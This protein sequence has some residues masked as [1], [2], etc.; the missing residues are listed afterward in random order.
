LCVAKVKRGPC[1]WHTC[2]RQWPTVS[3]IIADTADARPVH[4]AVVSPPGFAWFLRRRKS[5][6]IPARTAR[7]AS[8]HSSQRYVPRPYATFLLFWTRTVVHRGSPAEYR[9][10][11]INSVPAHRTAPPHH[12]HDLRDWYHE[13]DAW[14]L[15]MTVG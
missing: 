14:K 10:R 5:R 12:S 4:R 2:R 8:S 15:Q 7:P 13:R 11:L 3:R 1:V 9:S 6:P